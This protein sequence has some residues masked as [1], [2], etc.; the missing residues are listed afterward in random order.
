MEN[1]IIEFIKYKKG[2]YSAVMGTP[3]HDLEKC[4]YFHEALSILLDDINLQ[5]RSKLKEDGK[6]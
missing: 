2:Y 3:G 6:Q 5:F 1:E 4:K